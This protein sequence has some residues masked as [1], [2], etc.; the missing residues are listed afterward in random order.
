MNLIKIKDE[1]YVIVDDSWSRNNIII[2]G[3]YFLYQFG[4]C[5][6]I[7]QH[8]G[9]G[10]PNERKN[11][12]KITHST[13]PL[14]YI[15]TDDSFKN[16]EFISLQEVKEII[17]EVDIEENAL[18]YASSDVLGEVNPEAYTDKQ[19]GLLHGYIDGY[20]KALEDNKEKKYKENDISRAVMFGKWGGTKVDYEKFL[21]SLQSKTEWKL[22]LIDNKFKLK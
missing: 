15:V 12:F 17:G 14:E 11:C 21:Q 3:D 5:P 7:C 18:G 16:Y 1:H 8:D 2:K 9:L 13:Q 20:N 4:D 6:E 22:E 10:N 19:I